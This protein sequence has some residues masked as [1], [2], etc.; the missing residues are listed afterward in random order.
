MNSYL[1][2]SYEGSQEASLFDAHIKTS[3]EAFL[4]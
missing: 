2:P 3:Y 1:I 4:S